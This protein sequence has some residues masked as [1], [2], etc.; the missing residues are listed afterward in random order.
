[1]SKAI[2]NLVKIP[3]KSGK[4]ISIKHNVCYKK[5]KNLAHYIFLLYCPPTS[6][7]AAVICPSEQTLQ[8]SIKAS[9]IF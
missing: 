4:M 1:M 6:N 2:D 5:S 8:A 7:N 3:V 9:K